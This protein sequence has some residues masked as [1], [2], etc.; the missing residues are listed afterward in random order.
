[1]PYVPQL[2]VIESTPPLAQWPA[3]ILP[4]SGEVTALH[5]LRMPGLEYMEISNTPMAQLPWSDLQQLRQLILYETGFTTLEAWRL[6]MLTGCYLSYCYDLTT[7][8]LHGLAELTDLNLYNCTHVTD[9]DL[10]GCPNL[11]NVYFFYCDLSAAVIDQVLAD[12]VATGATDG[13]L[14]SYGNSA[15]SNPTGQASV[16][17]L[18]SRGWYIEFS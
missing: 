1:M 18:A 16:A 11:I 12:L 6:P 7:I 4:W 8:D 14:A 9:I 5:R 3:L 2:P 10:S 13:Y 17:I 15:P